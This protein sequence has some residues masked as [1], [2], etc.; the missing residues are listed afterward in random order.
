MRE[1]TGRAKD[2][3]YIHD[4]I[5]AIGDARPELRKLWQGTVRP[6]FSPKERSS[7]EAAPTTLLGE[8]NDSAREAV[9]IAPERL[10][11]ALRLI[12]T[13]EVGRS[14]ILLD[15]F[16]NGARAAGKSTTKSLASFL[17]SLCPTVRFVEIHS[18]LSTCSESTTT[19]ETAIM[20]TPL[21]RAG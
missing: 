13:C 4:T 8:V 14:A 12:E 1:P 21:I 3:L 11:S 7:I 2:L 9:K 15:A 20:K 5:E 16:M 6:L 19:P 17:F 10:P 18:A